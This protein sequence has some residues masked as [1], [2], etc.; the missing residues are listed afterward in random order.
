[1]QK[2][3]IKPPRP[4][5]DIS[6]ITIHCIFHHDVSVADIWSLPP[7]SPA[8]VAVATWDQASASYTACP[9][10]TIQYLVVVISNSNQNISRQTASHNVW[11]LPTKHYAMSCIAGW[12]PHTPVRW[13]PVNS[14]SSSWSQCLREREDRGVALANSRLAKCQ[15]RI[16][17]SRDE[18]Y[19]SL[20]QQHLTVTLHHWQI[21]TA[22]NIARK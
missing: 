15:S 14:K 21:A 1:M 9:L 11:L 13:L 8:A 10:E 7:W 12:F 3:V 2:K 16:W 20:K 6:Y 22:A 4:P 18:R 5:A 19:T 17:R